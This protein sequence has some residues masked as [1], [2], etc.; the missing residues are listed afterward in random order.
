[1]IL[2]FLS[3]EQLERVQHDSHGMAIRSS[4]N[5]L[6]TPDLLN[7]LQDKNFTTQFV[8]Q[9]HTSQQ[10]V[11]LLVLYGGDQFKLTPTLKG[12]VA[13]ATL[14]VESVISL[15]YDNQVS[16]RA[17]E[18]QT[19]M[20]STF[21]AGKGVTII[22]NAQGHLLYVNSVV[23]ELFGMVKT[24]ALNVQKIEHFIDIKDRHRV[25]SAVTKS[26][27]NP[28]IARYVD[29]IEFHRR[30]L[31]ED[32]SKADEE[33]NNSDFENDSFYLDLKIQGLWD[34]P[35]V[36]GCLVSL[37]NIP[38]SHHRWWHT[39]GVFPRY[40]CIYASRCIYICLNVLQTT[41]R[42]KPRLLYNS[43][44]GDNWNNLINLFKFLLLLRFEDVMYQPKQCLI[45]KLWNLKNP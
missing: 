26:K 45:V 35:A 10:F 42:V 6:Q 22:V 5:Y 16:R 8:S 19:M 44:D 33:S 24:E 3:T 29:C 43:R 39:G 17:L 37:T 1:M 30:A 38:A 14:L 7:K 40:I 4:Q 25:I 28:K 21:G 15:E 31:N 27:Q 11:G 9:I 18:E 34:D 32:D 20:D 41:F 23:R 13:D 36:N 2:L 12:I